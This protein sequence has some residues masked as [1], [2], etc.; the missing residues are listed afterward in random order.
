MERHAPSTLSLQESVSY[1]PT[2]SAQPSY[3]PVLYGNDSM[4]M[5][6]SGSPRASDK[7]Y[8][9]VTPMTP[10]EERGTYCPSP[11][12]SYQPPSVSSVL[13]E[14]SSVPED[15][16]IEENVP[17]KACFGYAVRRADALSDPE[18][19]ALLIHGRLAQKKYPS[20]LLPEAKIAKP[21]VQIDSTRSER[22]TVQY[23]LPSY[24]TW[25]CSVVVR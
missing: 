6:L 1:L 12:L 3:M 24:C 7:F 16:I 25:I 5:E 14:A 20:V 15:T 18:E 11:A 13:S 9:A 8:P 22:V 17:N 23:K 4:S 10:L 2:M 19:G 21:E